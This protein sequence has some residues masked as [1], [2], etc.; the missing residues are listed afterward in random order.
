MDLVDED[1]QA[2]RVLGDLVDHAL[3]AFL[4]LAPVLRAGDHPRHVERHQAL[5]G[6]RLGHVVVDD[7]LGDALHDRGLADAGVA[8]QH[9]VVLRAAREDLD[10]LLDL[11]GPADHGIELPLAGLLREVSAVLV[12][13]LCRARRAPTRLAAL[14]AADD[15]AAQLRVR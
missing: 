2:V 7:P 10:R 8:E 4:E 15:R 1:D 3:Q 11:I 12:E 13:R 6:E 14:D 9:R 5:A